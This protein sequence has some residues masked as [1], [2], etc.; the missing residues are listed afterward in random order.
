MHGLQRL[1]PMPPPLCSRPG[2]F[3]PTPTTPLGLAP[4][5]QARIH[6][7]RVR[8]TTSPEPGRLPSLRP[9]PRG[10]SGPDL[11]SLF[12]LARSSPAPFRLPRSDPASVKRRGGRF[13]LL[14]ASET[15]LAE[16]DAT[17]TG[18]DA[19]HRCLQPT[20]DTSTLRTVRFPAAPPSALRLPSCAH[21]R[22]EPRASPGW[23]IA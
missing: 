2:F 8:M 3:R 6:R 15:I 17:T 11:R 1:A 4:P 22:P 10:R 14:L 12:T 7:H 21:P 16:R 20:H 23:S 9:R 19:S 5:R 18:E 13:K